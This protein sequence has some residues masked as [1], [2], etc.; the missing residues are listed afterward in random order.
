[1]TV[2]L[3]SLAA[4]RVPGRSSVASL[5]VIPNP[6]RRG[7]ALGAALIL[8]ACGPGATPVPAT[9]SPA[10]TT[11][12]PAP[13]ASPTASPP[14]TPSSSTDGVVP[15]LALE[16][17]ASGFERPLLVTNG[18]D[19]T[20]RLYVVE[21]G[22][23]VWILENGTR[24][25]SPFL[26][27]S[28]QITS[29]GERGLLGLA[30]HPDFPDDPRVFVDYT[31]RSGDTVVA[32]FELGL[33]AD[34]VDPA[35]ELQVITIEQPYANHNGGALAFD[36]DGM[37]LVAMGDGGS[38]GDP[39][40]RAENPGQL[41][42]KILR[43]DV[44]VD[45]G[46]APYAIP[47]GNPFRDGGGRPEIAHLGLRNP[48]RLSIDRATGDLWLGDVGQGSV[49]E[50][51]VARAGELGLDFGW[52]T[53][54]GRQ[55]YEPRTGCDTAGKTMPVAEYGHDVGCTVVGGYVYRGTL[56]PQLDGTYVYGDYCSGRIWTLDAANP[57]EPVLA[58]K[59]DGSIGSFG[60]DEAGELYLADIGNGAILRIVPAG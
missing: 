17:V 13:T 37:L 59:L 18:G 46:G 27:V 11:P 2:P 39:E 22:G 43:L 9:P 47:A 1:M 6:M 34:A 19:G 60:E 54:E 7:L 15:V 36:R 12:T 29:G 53:L 31:N 5:L 52:N 30:F 42:G 3:A 44:D 57:G 21:Q 20:G 51:D 38:G 4:A 16:P 10:P 55:C 26:D 41:L 25:D 28:D 24:I 35:T 14:P 23:F 33:D 49:E 8:A 56:H 40:D 48:W 32:S 58:A 45:T 50:I